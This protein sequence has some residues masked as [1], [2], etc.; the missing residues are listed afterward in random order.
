MGADPAVTAT[1]GTNP[2]PDT[3]VGARTRKSN[4]RLRWRWRLLAAAFVIS[5]G[6]FVHAWRQTRNG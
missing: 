1:A 3:L 2:G 6:A 4:F 5:A